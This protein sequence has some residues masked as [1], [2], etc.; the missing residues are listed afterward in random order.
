MAERLDSP[1][2]ALRGC[3][4]SGVHVS[5]TGGPLQMCGQPRAAL[6]VHYRRPSTRRN[7]AHLGLSTQSSG[8]LSSGSSISAGGLN[9]GSK[10][11]KM[12]PDFLLSPSIRTSYL[13]GHERS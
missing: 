11:S 7:R 8:F 12:E 4:S 10:S 13:R 1:S 9:G 6:A 3:L 2:A 5:P